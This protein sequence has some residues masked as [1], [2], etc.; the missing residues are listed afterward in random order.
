MNWMFCR[1]R[2]WV[3]VFSFRKHESGFRQKHVITTLTLLRSDIAPWLFY[4]FNFL[5]FSS[6]HV[7]ARTNTNTHSVV[8]QTNQLPQG[9]LACEK[10]QGALLFSLWFSYYTQINTVELFWHP[11]AL[12]PE[13]FS[14]S[15]S[16]YLPLFH[17]LSVW[18]TH[19]YSHM[20]LRTYSGIAKQTSK[21]TYTHTHTAH[22]FVWRNVFSGW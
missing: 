10:G 16:P 3:F 21:Q 20:M 1:I 14:V 2:V 7:C 4:F 5:K 11:R 15:Q 19:T 9:L 12:D 22:A 8:R 18:Q 17:C 6:I 13:F